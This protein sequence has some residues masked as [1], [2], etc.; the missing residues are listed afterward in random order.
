MARSMAHLKLEPN[1]PPRTATR[2]LTASLA[3]MVALASV[4]AIVLSLLGYGFALAV[5]SELNIPHAQLLG[6]SSDLLSLS[7]YAI[8]E[9][10]TTPFW[11]IWRAQQRQMLGAAIV[12]SIA[13]MVVG[14]FI[15]RKD[16][17]PG[18]K[19]QRKKRRTP[20]Q[21]RRFLIRLI[22]AFGVFSG[23]TLYALYAL[24]IA[25]VYVVIALLATTPAIGFASGQRFVEK[26][27]IQPEMCAPLRPRS[28]RLSPRRPAKTPASATCL[29]V[30]A[31]NKVIAKGRLVAATTGSI[32]L[33]DPTSGVARRVP[34]QGVV[35]QPISSL[36]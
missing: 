35:V 11:D 29:Q 24:T 12:T 5:E 7:T 25:A 13:S 30:S 4:V 18:L 26:H 17:W 19:W 27:V 31:D 8:M 6:T 36:D 23:L 22:P 2:T 14:A 33:F 34:T 1:T 16:I 32:V 15:A 21:R 28:A 9:A 3:A 20:E 10:L